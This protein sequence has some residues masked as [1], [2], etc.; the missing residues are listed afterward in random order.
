MN[1][2]RDRKL[3]AILFADIAGYTAMM[4]EDEAI[5]R[6]WVQKFRDEL[7]AKVSQYNGAIIQFYGD[8]CLCVYESAVNA[9]S[10]ASE[11]QQAFIAEPSVPVRIGLHSGEVYFEADNVYGDAVNIAS[12]V[13][14]IGIPGA[15]L[16]SS[17]IRNQIKNQ[18][19]FSLTSLGRFEFK[20]V[21]EG[22]TVYALANEG[23]LIP[24]REEMKGKIKT[25]APQKNQWRIL[26][27]VAILFLVVFGF[28]KWKTYNQLELESDSAQVF[29]QTPLSKE[30]REKRVAIL[31]FENKTQREDLEDFGIMI[32]DWITQGLMATGEANVISAANIQNQ[33]SKADIGSG[34]NPKLAE[35]TGV[36]VMLKGRYYLQD[37]QL[38]IYANIIAVKSGEVLH[39]LTP[40]QGDRKDML[41][42]LD[43]LTQEVL[44]Y[45]AVKKQKR[46][47]Q[48]PPKYEAYKEWK[49]GEAAYFIDF[50]T[51]EKHLLK[52][53][54]LDTTFYAPLLRIAFLYENSGKFDFQDTIIAF[55]DKRTSSFTQWEQLRHDFF[56]A[57]KN[58]RWLEAA[59]VAEK[60]YLLDKSDELSV[61]HAG[62]R[63]ILANYPEKGL[64]VLSQ[65][66]P[67]FI[68]ETLGIGLREGY[69][70]MAYYKLKKYQEA[71]LL[72][73][74]YTYQKVNY[75]SAFYHLNA[76]IHLDS[77]ELV[78][79]N[80]TNYAQK[81]VYFSSGKE[82]KQ[83]V[84][85]RWICDRLLLLDKKK[86]LEQYTAMLEDYAIQHI[87]DS[88]YPQNMGYINWYMKDYEQAL[89]WWSKESLEEET[90]D[91]IISLMD[92]FARLGVCYAYL[93]DALMAEKQIESI[94]SIETKHA[95][96][97]GNKY[98]YIARILAALGQKNEATLSLSKAIEGRAPFVWGT[99]EEDPF[100]KPIMTYPHFKSLI[101][102]KN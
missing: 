99:F 90:P 52:A 59:Q 26:P 100:L 15:V 28:W 73:K 39:A 91:K 86:L 102:P 84:L 89:R 58:G 35:I 43:K 101:K 37:N 54:E 34:P 10:C 20:N 85:L 40:M 50:K 66:D 96:Y 14:S 80:L 38:L 48:N 24:N 19:E 68:D 55:L 9:L 11:I 61:T 78:N 46:F 60:R 62:G 63:Y 41:Q 5:A 94:F 13:E 21:K 72:A 7:R 67:E 70:T 77:M 83:D 75:L 53:F 42:L 79:K 64:K 25:S 51:S 92:Y 57:E 2:Q 30:I 29:S 87:D 18:S 4:Q 47:L 1:Q 27:I 36:D 22:M 81:G 93:G 97:L 69:K 65:F 45:W 95:I 56:K 32:S 98:Y 44:S 76:L 33:I 88:R 12:R 6:Q 31:I 16:L 23:F 71:H 8:G 74:K 82:F 3:M 49:K 17:N